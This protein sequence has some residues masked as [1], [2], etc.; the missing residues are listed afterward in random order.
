MIQC[1]KQ[2]AQ[3]VSTMKNYLLII[4]DEIPLAQLM[5]RAATESGYVTYHATTFKD[6]K[7]YLETAKFDIIVA[8]LFL[9][10]VNDFPSY[11]KYLIDRAPVIVMSGGGQFLHH[12]ADL[13]LTQAKNE[14]AAAVFRK[15]V[16]LSEIIAEMDKIL[17]R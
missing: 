7:T 4:E 2:F 11:L 8:D 5:E 15:P 13:F 6:A 16:K 3:G 12:Q 14:G 9:P 10:D 1:L 17:G